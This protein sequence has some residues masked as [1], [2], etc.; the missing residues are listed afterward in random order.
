MAD[1]TRG[2]VLAALLANLG[3]G[4]AKAAGGVLTCSTALLAEAAHSVADTLHE[5]FL[6]LSLSRASRPA[7]RTHPFG[8][9]KERFFWALLAAVGIFLSGAVFSV[10]EGLHA[11]LSRGERETSGREYAVIYGVLA[12]SLVLDSG[13]LA[14]ALRQVRREAADASRSLLA[15]IRRS[16]DPTVK[17][18][19]SEDSIA[20]LG[21]LIALAGTVLHQ[22]TGSAR[23]GRMLRSGAGEQA[24]GASQV[25]E[26]A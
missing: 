17:T 12:V 3:V 6:L 13:S 1:E 9:G 24:G 23:T 5:V 22:V 11:L 10:A 21:V 19:A 4:L 20:V 18:V 16:P 26:P 7:D 25:D 14:K 8:Y 2:T 15:Y